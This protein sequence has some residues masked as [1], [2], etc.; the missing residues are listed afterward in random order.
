MGRAVVYDTSKLFG[1]VARVFWG[2]PNA[3]DAMNATSA[4]FIVVGA[5]H[6]APSMSTTE[7]N[8]PAL[9]LRMCYRGFNIFIG[10]FGPGHCLVSMLTKMLLVVK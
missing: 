5:I 3:G 9:C 8:S 1:K 7:V 10:V 6:L 4:L 2:T